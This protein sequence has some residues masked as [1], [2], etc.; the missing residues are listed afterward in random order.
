ML[1]SKEN[2]FWVNIPLRILKDVN[3][4]FWNE[5]FWLQKWQVG[6]PPSQVGPSQEMSLFTLDKLLYKGS[7]SSSFG[8]F[9]FLSQD[10]FWASEWRTRT[11]KAEKEGWI[12][13]SSLSLATHT[14]EGIY[15]SM[16]HSF[17]GNCSRGPNFFRL[18]GQLLQGR[19][20]GSA[21][22]RAKCRISVGNLTW[23]KRLGL[24]IGL[25]VSLI[26]QEEFLYWKSCVFP[27]S[28]FSKGK[29]CLSFVHCDLYYSIVFY[30]WVFE[31]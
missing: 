3:L 16:I 28:G 1:E 22:S 12:S 27:Y 31:V 14:C 30:C 24:T 11:K 2:L 9:T 17:W 7:A 8:K 20:S 10:N 23:S 13:L 19:N 18:L 5:I 4:N 21:G 26:E 25:G 15:F 29:S 6:L